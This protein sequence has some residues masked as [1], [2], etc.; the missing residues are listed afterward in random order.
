MFWCVLCMVDGYVF[1][2]DMYMFGRNI[3]QLSVS[4]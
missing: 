4:E 3:G 1:N 2:K